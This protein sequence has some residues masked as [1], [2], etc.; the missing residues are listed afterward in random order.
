[1]VG[2]S[3][4]GHA[5]FDSSTVVRQPLTLHLNHDG[6]VN[7][8]WLGDYQG[9]QFAFGALCTSYADNSGARVH[10]AFAKLARP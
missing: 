10:V 4:N 7:P 5:D 9:A 1:M 3:S 6:F 2:R 8:A